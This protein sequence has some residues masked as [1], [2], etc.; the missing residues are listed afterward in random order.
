MQDALAAARAR[1]ASKS[2]RATTMRRS[3]RSKASIADALPLSNRINSL[4]D[5]LVHARL[6]ASA[7]PASSARS[8]LERLRARR[9]DDARRLSRLAQGARAHPRALR[10]ACGVLRRLRHAVG[11][12]RRAG[13]PAVDR[14]SAVRRAVLAARRSGAVAA[15]V[16][17]RRHA[18][19]LAGAGLRQRGC[20][21]V[22]GRGVAARPSRRIGDV[23]GR[24]HQREA[25]R[26][27]RA[28]SRRRAEACAQLSRPARARAGA[29]ARGPAASSSTSRSTKTPRCIR[30]CAGSIA[31]AFRSRSARRSC[32]PSRPTRRAAATTP[33][34]WSRGSP[35][36]AR[37]TASASASRWRTSARPGSTRSPAPIAPRMVEN[38][39]CQEIVI[40][41]DELD[42]R[43]PRRSTACRCRSRR[44]AGTTRLISRPAT[45]SP[46][47]PTP[48]SRTSA[49][50]AAS[51]RRRA[52]LG[53]NP[54][55]ELR[56][57][58]YAHWEKY[59][60]RGEPMPCASWSA[61]RRSVSYASV[62]KIA[63]RSRRACG[64]RRARGRADQRRA[65]Q[66]RR[67]AGARRGRDRDRGLHQHRVA[68]A[69]GAVRRVARLRQSA[70]IQRLHGCDGDHAAAPSDPDL[71]HQP[72][73]A[74]RIE[75]HPPRGDGAGVPASSASR[76]WRS[77]ASSASRCTSR[78]PASMR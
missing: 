60:A 54:S 52:R 70:G 26:R 65:R 50:T 40:T 75:R 22:R 53:M 19:R 34:C 6:R 31:A 17:D 27:A 71:V 18:A 69:G 30:W 10:R 44:R 57:G 23:D 29:R 38:A 36:T 78:S 14:Q 2:A 9:G 3:R 33:R 12:R 42:Q 15:A 64:R 41:G 46:G 37:S 47:I 68:G 24:A 66:D 77:A 25:P 32:S 67:P 16:R 4:G 43:R 73:D 39:P 56:A 5:A 8:M 55:V 63:G 49:T 72:G 21:G 20:R 61:A 35:P 76:C 62:Q 11:A 58:I 1:P 59:K 7:T 51:S 28:L 48:A 74:E 45:T 13:R